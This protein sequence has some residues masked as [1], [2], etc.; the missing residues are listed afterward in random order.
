M[1]YFLD[2]DIPVSHMESNPISFFR[3]EEKSSP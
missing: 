3:I 2:Y 1:H